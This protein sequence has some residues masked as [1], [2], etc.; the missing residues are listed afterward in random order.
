MRRS[1][2]PPDEGQDQESTLTEDDAS[3]MLGS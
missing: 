3:R 1:T 2:T